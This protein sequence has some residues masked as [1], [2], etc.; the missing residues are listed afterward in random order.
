MRLH[1]RH[2]TTYQYDAPITCA[3]QTLRLAPQ[4]HR[5]LS[6]LHWH[7][8]GEATRDLPSYIDGYGNIVHSHTVRQ[9]HVGAA[10][11]V[12]GEVETAD[13]DGVLAGTRETLPPS[14]FLRVT[15]LTK[16]SEAIEAL[17]AH[18]G[19]SPSPL[20]RLHAAMALVQESVAYRT[21]TTSSATT[22]A[23]AVARGTGVCQDHAHVFIAV[24]RLLKTPARYVS[25]YL[26]LPDQRDA[27]PACHAWAE[28]HVEDLGWVGFD[29]SNRIC[30]TDAYVRTAAGLDYWSAAPVRGLWQGR[31]TERLSVEVHVRQPG[32]LH[33][34]AQ[35]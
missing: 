29:P 10:I 31:A 17:A 27:Q 8:R 14:F 34:A 13:T 30:P 2:R 15:P 11:D 25:G 22:A 20:E 7:V 24:A 18:A 12:E 32:D 33:A 19:R 4:P 23:E 5:G 16:P 28:A 21:G 26:F 9:A 6:V 1:I 35:Q 3:V